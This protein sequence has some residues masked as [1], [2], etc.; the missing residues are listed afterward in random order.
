MHGV[1]TSRESGWKGGVTGREEGRSLAAKLC[2]VSAE[3]LGYEA[4]EG[5]SRMM[6]DER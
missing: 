4:T 2:A 6:E 5:E 1:K 3:V